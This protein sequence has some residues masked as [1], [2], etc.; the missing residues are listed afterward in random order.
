MDQLTGKRGDH[1]IYGAIGNSVAPGD[2][3]SLQWFDDASKTLLTHIFGEPVDGVPAVEDDRPLVTQPV[4]VSEVS[5]ERIRIKEPL[6]HD[7]RPTWKV[8]AVQTCHLDHVGIE[9]FA[10]TF[11]MVPFNEHHLEAGYNAIALEDVRHGWISDVAVINADTAFNVTSSSQVTLAEITTSGRDGHYSAVVQSSYGVLVRDF[12]F[13]AA[14]IHNPSFGTA[15]TGSVF[16]HGVVFDPR[17]DQHR[18][19]NHQNL[20]DQIWAYARSPNSAQQLFEHGGHPDFGPTAGA[21]N[22]FWN[23]SIDVLGRPTKPL[24]PRPTRDAPHARIVGLET[25][26]PIELDYGP[27]AHIEG[28]NRHGKIATPSLYAYQRCMRL[29]SKPH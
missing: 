25:S 28:V 27:A 14:A 21:F 17:F 18:G 12:A 2:V 7:L 24:K 19:L 23:V 1:E 15:A 13:A 22:V 9:G 26:S 3:I 6:L 10:V 5:A 29:D 16:T 4:T 20:F 11:P 8:A